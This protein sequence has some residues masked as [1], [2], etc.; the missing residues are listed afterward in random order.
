[1]IRPLVTPL[2]QDAI[3]IWL[4]SATGLPI[5]VGDH[6]EPRRA[7]PYVGFT[8]PHGR[9]FTGDRQVTEWTTSLG[10]TT[11]TITA[12]EEARAAALLGP[13]VVELTRSVGETAGDFA[14][15]W[16]V[17]AS[18]WL[19]GRATATAAGSVV[20]VTPLD[21][22]TL[23]AAVALEGLT[24]SSLDGGPT[25]WVQRL[26]RATCHIVIFASGSDE[27]GAIG[28]GL[29][30]YTIEA[31][32][33]EALSWDETKQTL[34]GG[35]LVPTGTPRGV[36]AYASAVSGSRRESRTEFDITLGWTG[37]Y[38]RTPEA[39][40]SVEYT[41]GLVSPDPAV[42]PIEDTTEIEATP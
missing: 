2:A 5:I 8:F 17:W 16:A 6:N 15:R 18:Y 24:V 22:G 38:Q 4:R 30:T 23:A 40:T 9:T 32:I 11:I 26:Y 42:D 28:D 3:A 37:F 25:R 14:T 39:A 19:R 12:A 21:V 20:T 27:P 7:K 41:A 1:V 34:K 29:D 36:P 31:A 35:W 10:V 13:A 33:R